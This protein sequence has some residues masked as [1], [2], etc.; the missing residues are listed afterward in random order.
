MGGPII[1]AARSFASTGKYQGDIHAAYGMLGAIFI[2]CLKFK[3]CR[4]LDHGEFD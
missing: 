1:T 4:L 3:C 2:A